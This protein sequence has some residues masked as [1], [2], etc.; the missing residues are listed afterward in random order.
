MA[1]YMKGKF[2][3]DD[4]NIKKVNR[5]I[6]GRCISLDWHDRI[7][8]KTT[9]FVNKNNKYEEKDLEKTVRQ[10]RKEKLRLKRKANK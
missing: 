4:I 3:Y 1:Q 5:I 7:E 9:L 10:L 6:C 8:D 2:L